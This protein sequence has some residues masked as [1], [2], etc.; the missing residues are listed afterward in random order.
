MNPKIKQLLDNNKLLNAF[1]IISATSGSVRCFLSNFVMTIT[2]SVWYQTGMNDSL[3]KPYI[4]ISTITG[5][6]I[7]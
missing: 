7:P 5:L 4:I 1:D 2:W 3:C 6:S